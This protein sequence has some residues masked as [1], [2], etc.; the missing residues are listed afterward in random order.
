LCLGGCQSR[1]YEIL[2]FLSALARKFKEWEMKPGPTWKWFLLTNTLY[3]S[4][5]ISK[6]LWG[7]DGP[8]NVNTYE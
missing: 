8:N 1:N 3:T 6:I 4:S 7:R 5:A 2:F